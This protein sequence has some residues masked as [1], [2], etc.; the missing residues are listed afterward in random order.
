[1]K[2]RKLNMECHPDTRVGGVVVGHAVI[3]IA[4]TW[5]MMNGEM[6]REIRAVDLEMAVIIK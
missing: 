4:C 2:E 5:G 1:M 6:M 3:D